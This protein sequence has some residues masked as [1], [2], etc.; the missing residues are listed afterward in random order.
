MGK[1]ASKLLRK[2]T[3]RGKEHANNEKKNKRKKR[4]T[5]RKSHPH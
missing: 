1:T 5:E 2:Q 3:R 4:D